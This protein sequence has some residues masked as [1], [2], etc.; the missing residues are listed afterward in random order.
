[1]TASVAVIPPGQVTATNNPQVALYTVS[2]PLGGSV[3]IQF[4]T[5]TSYGLTTW[6]QTASGNDAPLGIYVAGM[7]ASTA[8]HMRA[9]ITLSN[10]AQFTDTDHV[11]TTG[12]I[13]SYAIPPV[14]VS[15]PAGLTPQPGVEM[16]IP[17]SPNGYATDLLGNVIWTYR[18]NV[19]SDDVLQPLKLM[20]NG[21]FLVCLGPDSEWPLI[22]GNAPGTINVINEVDA[23]GNLIRQ[24]SIATL[25]SALAS[26]GFNLVADTMHH[27]VTPLPNGHLLLIVNS[28]KQFTDLPGY[29][30]T[31]TVLG[32]QIVDLDANWNPVWVWNSFDNLDINRHP[33]NFPDWTHTNAILYSQSDGNIVISQRN[34]NWLLKLNYQNGAG[35]G[36]V[37]WHLGEGGDFTLVGGADPTDWFWGQ[38][39]PSFSSTNT[40]GTFP[41]AVFD[42]GNDREFPPGTSCSQPPQAAC[43]SMCACYST[44]EIYQ[45]DETAKT[46]T[47]LFRDVPNLYS[48]FGGNAEVLANGDLEYDLS[49]GLPSGGTVVLEVTQQENPRQ[50]VWQMTIQSV[51]AYRAFRLPSLYPGVQW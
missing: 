50:V 48:F 44:G 2:P 18:S 9:M 29:P 49:A 17:G 6:T 39:G 20:S 46:A 8:Y 35:D 10:G 43:Q 19:G 4:G 22:G 26:A 42:D 14:T 37:L 32:D 16:I 11:F 33:M 41:L 5:S 45:L 27:D 30:G 38:H 7:L 47:I 28:T 40:E 3:S 34:Q 12:S 31:T 13:S 1:V 25:N 51:D 21:H 15:T 24:L 23:A 36:S